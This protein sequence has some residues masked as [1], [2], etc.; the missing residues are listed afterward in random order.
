MCDYKKTYLLGKDWI[1]RINEKNSNLNK[2]GDLTLPG[3]HHS[4][5]FKCEWTS[6]YYARYAVTQDLDPL[7]QMN[8]GVRVF[9]L[10]LREITLSGLSGTR[11]SEL[12]LSHGNQGINVLGMKWADFLEDATDFLTMNPSE[13]LVWAGNT[14][15]RIGRLL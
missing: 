4:G 1:K 5:L 12:Y 11:P 13:F 7:E 3:T 2:L 10:R 9:D 8:I 6:C 15:Q 14:D